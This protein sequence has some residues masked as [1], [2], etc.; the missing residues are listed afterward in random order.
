MRFYYMDIK[1]EEYF[2]V[3][4]VLFPFSQLLRGV[5]ESNVRRTLRIQLT[6]K[7]PVRFNYNGGDGQ[8]PQRLITASGRYRYLC[9]KPAVSSHCSPP[10]RRSVVG[11]GRRVTG[12]NA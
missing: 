9:T 7:T 4:N 12:Y 2:L 3:F 11:P 8:K 1:Y 6:T 5:L 10:P